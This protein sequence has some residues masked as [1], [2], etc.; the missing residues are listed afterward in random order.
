MN[1][2]KLAKFFGTGLI[3]VM[4]AGGVQAQSVIA[5]WTSSPGPGGTEGPGTG[6]GLDGAYATYQLSSF[7]AYSITLTS[8]NTVANPGYQF[9][10][11]ELVFNGSSLTGQLWNDGFVDATGTVN[12]NTETVDFS[13]DNANL[14]SQS[15]IVFTAYQNGGY[16]AQGMG[17]MTVNAVE[18]APEPGT[19]ALAGFG[20]TLVFLGRKSLARRRTV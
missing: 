5:H 3:A 8:L 11:F 7:G 18:A 19:F 6:N 4:C 12:G 16:N 2:N 20:L 17:H 13:F 10:D 15:T 9:T 14:A 1:Y